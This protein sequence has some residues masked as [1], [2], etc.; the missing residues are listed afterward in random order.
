M[1]EHDL[2]AGIKFADVLQA[3]RD[4]AAE[5]GCGWWRSWDLPDTIADRLGVKQQRDFASTG[6]Q[7]AAV[8]RFDSQCL[9]AFNALASEDVLVK[10]SKGERSPRGEFLGNE[11]QF[12]TPEAVAQAA[13]D[14]AAA[15][16]D[17]KASTR[18]WELIW[19]NLTARGLQPAQARG[20]PVNL[21]RDQWEDLLRSQ[22]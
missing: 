20:V 5:P 11:A 3:A 4:A 19:D 14:L 17:R 13:G 9:R 12:F 2:Y 22:S 1:S 18:R 16:A 10:V 6:T 15:Q 8:G 7:R 21:S